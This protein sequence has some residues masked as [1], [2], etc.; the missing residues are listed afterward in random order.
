MTTK[1][2]ILNIIHQY[3]LYCVGDSIKEVKNCAASPDEPDHYTKCPL[4]A[5][6]MGKDPNPSKSK[7]LL[8]LNMVEKRNK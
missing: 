2:E 5:Y 8:A 6:R 1:S 4:W 3:C 7:Q